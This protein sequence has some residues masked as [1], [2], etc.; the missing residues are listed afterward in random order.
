LDEVKFFPSVHFFLFKGRAAFF[1][2]S[3]ATFPTLAA[4]HFSLQQA[5]LTAVKF[6]LPRHWQFMQCC[7]VVVPAAICLIDL[8]LL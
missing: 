5:L 4:L 3:G 1:E 7:C 6:F 8:P 2:G